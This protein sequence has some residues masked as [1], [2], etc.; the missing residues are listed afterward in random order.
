MTFGVIYKSKTH[1]KL[2]GTVFYC[3]EYSQLLQRYADVKLYIVD[4]TEADFAWIKTVL[5]QKYTT[6][7]HN[8]VRVDKYTDL[9]GLGLGGALILDIVT[10]DAVKYLLSGD[11]ICYSNDSHPMWR[12][13]RSDRIVTYFGSYD[14]QPHDISTPLRLNFDIFKPAK[15]Q[16]GV[17][18]C[19]PDM[20]YISARMHEWSSRFACPVVTKKPNTGVGNI[21]DLVHS[22]HYVHTG[23]DKNNRVIPEAFWYG[24][25]VTFDDPYN[26]PADSAT[27][28]YHDILANGLG[29]YTL[30]DSDAMVQA[31][32]KYCG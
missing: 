17:F 26:L 22:M 1:K 13:A 8:L 2:N 18:V 12:P 27:L 28:R 6:P 31:C 23:K 4:I 15:H 3:Y 7:T 16:P 9:F 20:E 21:F 25:T 30:T 14:Y 5:E 32:L 10:L 24:K 19:A 29:T 11:I